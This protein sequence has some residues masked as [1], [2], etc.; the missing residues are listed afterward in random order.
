MGTAVIDEVLT[1]CVEYN[2][3]KLEEKEKFELFITVIQYNKT[4]QNAAALH[5]LWGKEADTLHH[6]P[7]K[8]TSWI[9]KKIPSAVII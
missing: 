7:I 9:I 3:L 2:I 8:I 5:S 1:G 4:D 6:W